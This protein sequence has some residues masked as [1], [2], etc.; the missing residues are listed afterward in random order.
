MLLL[1]IIPQSQAQGSGKILQD[2]I[3]LPLP[4][5]STLRAIKKRLQWSSNV[6]WD[7]GV[8][9]SHAE[10]Q[11]WPGG[12]FAHSACEQTKISVSRAASLVL[13]PLKPQQDPSMGIPTPMETRHGSL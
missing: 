9:L 1:L 11:G 3:P 13:N 10:A 5:D 12:W 8:K 7:R 2:C 6:I 4:G